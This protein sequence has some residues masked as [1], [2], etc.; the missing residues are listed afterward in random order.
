MWSEAVWPN[1]ADLQILKDG[2]A[3][4]YGNYTVSIGTELD[5]RYVALDYDSSSTVTLHADSDQN[6][7][8]SNDLTSINDPIQHIATNELFIEKSVNWD[9]SGMNN[10]TKAYIYAKI[11]DASRTRYFYAPT[12]LVFSSNISPV[13]S[14]LY[15]PHISTKNSWETEVCIINTSNSKS[16]TGNL[17]AY[18]N[19]G[20]EVTY[21]PIN[22]DANA[23]VEYTVGSDFLYSTNIGYMIFE[24]DSADMCGYMKFF[25]NAQYRGAIPATSDINSAD[26]YIPHIASNTTWWTGISL[27]NTTNASK[28]LT[29]EF[30]DGTTQTRTIAA[31]EHQ[32]FSIKSLFSD[33][34]QPNIKSAVIKNASGIVGLE[35]FASNANSGDNYL[36]G[37]LLK[38]DTTHNLDFPHIGNL[39]NWWTGIVAYNQSSITATMAITPYKEDGTVLTAQTVN[40]GPGIK[41]IRTAQTLNFPEGAAWFQIAST[42]ALT[43]FELFGTNDRKQLGGFTSVNISRTSGVFPK[44]EKNG[45]TG[46]ALVN[47]AN[48]SAT[49]TLTAYDDNGDVIDTENFL[50]S[51]HEKKVSLVENIFSQD[52]S[53]AT[54][55]SFSSGNAIVGFQLN[56]STDSMMLD[57][58]PGM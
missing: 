42:Q 24:S 19:A 58:L 7:Y 41:Y 10:G 53:A 50:L 11:S 55:I 1:I 36:S 44:I 29:I 22:L 37:V 51:A 6:P 32:I 16:L 12:C 56:G 13:I 54:Y 34:S 3:L 31:N 33:V 27:L 48:S 25:I 23:R 17:S 21:K 15:F 2:S 39:N 46:I 5:L 8:N 28:T 47:I 40:L 43:G 38:D 49:V 20:V 30:S 45:W 57:A 18:N 52:I 26:I 9:T 4:G 14:S 35:L